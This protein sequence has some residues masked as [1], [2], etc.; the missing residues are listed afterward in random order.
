VTIQAQIMDL[1]KRVNR[2]HGTAII[3]ISHN[4]ALVSQNC[5]RVLVMYAGRIVEELSRERLLA[6][7]R[8]PYTSALLASVPDMGRPQ[9]EPLAYIP[10]QAPDLADLP[11]GCP[12]HPR[13]ALAQDVCRGSRP[14]LRARPEGGRVACWVANEDL[15]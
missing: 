5:D 13:C 3:L 10:G 7:A 6:G 14:A 9:D 11:T 15:P 4:L 1:L 8:H 2:D 12:Y